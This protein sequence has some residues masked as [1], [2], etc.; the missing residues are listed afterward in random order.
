MKWSMLMGGASITINRSKIISA[1][2]YIG[3][4]TLL[5]VAAAGGPF[6]GISGIAFGIGCGAI[7]AASIAIATIYFTNSSLTLSF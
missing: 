3:A 5:K 7:A 6:A 1:L 2:G 4:G